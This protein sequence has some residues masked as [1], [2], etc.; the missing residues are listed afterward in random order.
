MKRES[1]IRTINFRTGRLNWC[2]QK[3]KLKSSLGY[4]TRII[5]WLNYF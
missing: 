5:V 4:C 3:I 1:E 2:I